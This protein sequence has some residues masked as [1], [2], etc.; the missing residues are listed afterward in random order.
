MRSFLCFLCFLCSVPLFYGCSKPS[1]GGD[2]NRGRALFQ[3]HCAPCHVTPPPD[4]LKQPPRLNG[5]FNSKTLPSG[6]PATDE[7][8]GMVIIQGLRTM[9]AFQGRLQEQDVKDLLAYLHQFQ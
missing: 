5:V 7:Q 6:A 2:V 4:L 9:P 8:V 1:N 3:I